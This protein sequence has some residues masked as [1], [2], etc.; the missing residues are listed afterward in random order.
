MKLSWTMTIIEMTRFYRN[1][2][3]ND[4]HRDD[5]LNDRDFINSWAPKKRD[6][7]D[8]NDDDDD[9]NVDEDNDEFN[10]DNDVDCEVGSLYCLS[11]FNCLGQCTA[12]KT[13]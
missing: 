7:D 9:V 8:D 1:D 10:D 2:T 6:D 5:A 4:F 13:L 11:S 12:C 3:L